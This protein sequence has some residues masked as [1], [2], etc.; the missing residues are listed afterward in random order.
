M[1]D[2]TDRY[3]VRPWHPGFSPLRPRRLANLVLTACYVVVAAL[4]GLRYSEL[5][6][7]RRGCV[8]PEQLAT[9]RFATGFEARMIKGRP[10]GGEV[11]RWTVIEEVAQAFALVE[12]LLSEAE[13][14]LRPVPARRPATPR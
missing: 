5:A 8:H 11:Q 13:L 12:R 7:M 2:P 1:S 9:A 10:F 6:E 4:S 14:A 3:P